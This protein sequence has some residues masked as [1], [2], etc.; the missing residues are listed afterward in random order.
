[1]FNPIQKISYLG[2]KITILVLVGIFVFLL[3][4]KII[5]ADTISNHPNLLLAQTDNNADLG[6]EFYIENCSSCHIPLPAE[7]LPTDAWQKII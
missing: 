5:Y 1:M 7:V 4:T 3:P 6:R 2:K